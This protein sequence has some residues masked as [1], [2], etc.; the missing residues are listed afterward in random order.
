MS[1][2][3]PTRYEEDAP[4]PGVHLR[5]V[6]YEFGVSRKTL[7][8][9]IGISYQQLGKLLTGHAPFT[10]AIAIW[11]SQAFRINPGFWVHAQA[12]YDLKR[13]RQ[14]TPPRCIEP[15]SKPRALPKEQALDRCLCGHWKDQHDWRA[16]SGGTPEA[17]CD[18]VGY[19]RLGGLIAMRE[20][21]DPNLGELLAQIPDDEAAE[22][23]SK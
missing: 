13:I 23:K 20:W 11:L 9:R 21:T 4:H 15:F 19:L 16:C 17:P 3:P 1:F 5:R 18:C 8:A 12:L 6:M 22:G 14:K 10:P 2:V 7:C